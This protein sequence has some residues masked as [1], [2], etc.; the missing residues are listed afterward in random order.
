MPDP[1]LTPPRTLDGRET[2]RVDVTR[3]P[4]HAVVLWVLPGVAT[5]TLIIDLVLL[6]VT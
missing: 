2:S 4:A 3:G 1:A 5:W 6:I